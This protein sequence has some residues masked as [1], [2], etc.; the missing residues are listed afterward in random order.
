MKL[1]KPTA[2]LTVFLPRGHEGLG[3][4]KLSFIYYTI[5]IAFLVKMLNYNVEKF[6]F[7]AR[8]SFKL[9]TKKKS[10]TFFGLQKRNFLGYELDKNGTLN[11]KT[12]FGCQ[13]DCVDLVRYTKKI[14]VNLESRSNKIVVLK[15]VT[16]VRPALTL[17]KVYITFV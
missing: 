8:E 15:N 12:T 5:R 1:Y 11:C 9:E 17:E 10:A 7:I 14:G 16:V 6:S 2:Q 3:V 13:S 4:K